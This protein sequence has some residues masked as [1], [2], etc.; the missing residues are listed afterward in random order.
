MNDADDRK[1]ILEALLAEAS[2]LGDAIADRHEAAER[3]ISVAG[4]L[5]GV[6]LTLGLKDDQKIILIG[7]PIGIAIIMLY[8]VQIYTDAAMHSGHREAIE[9]RLEKEF[10]QSVLVGQAWVAKK[11]A[12]RLSTKLSFVLIMLVW[13]G[14]SY[15][16]GHTLWNWDRI[17]GP[18]HGVF[19]WFYIVLLAAACGSFLVAGYENSKAESNAISLAANGWR[20]RLQP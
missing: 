9:V 12:R 11:H 16:G 5:S 18:N 6:G 7:L 1:F 2:R 8:M 3:F 4:A 10:G 13:L 15:L 20:G 14:A 17:S 19:F